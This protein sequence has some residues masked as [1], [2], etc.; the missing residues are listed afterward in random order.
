MTRT[1][2]TLLLA[3]S[4]LTLAARAQDAD[5]P[6][7]EEKPAPRQ[8][9]RTYEAQLKTTDC[10][11]MPNRTTTVD[12]AYAHAQLKVIPLVN[13]TAQSDAN[14]ILIAVRN[15]FDPSIKIYL[16]ADQ[17]AIAVTTYPE[18]IARIESLIHILDRPH[19]SY[20]LT[21]TLTESDAGK[22]L[23]VQH[24][25][26]VAV[27]GQ[28]TTMKQGSKIPVAT[29]SYNEGD[30]NTQTQFTYL[31][32]GMNFDVTA[33]PAGSGISLKAKVEQSSTAPEPVTIAGVNE[34]I[35]RQS[36]IDGTALVTFGKP[37][38][39]GAVDVPAST[40]HIDIDVT[41]EPIP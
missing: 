36:V 13:A 1:I 5:K 3:T 9:F 20:R 8:D 12:C 34:P 27:A 2:L 15:L 40:R 25:S 41:A 38:T 7:Q 6:A 23:G 17:S 19:P 10:R 31:D 35:V 30:K 33:T 4:S 11:K 26:L 29:G 22:R 28:R 18:E 21:F 37:L 24:F 32:I 16:I 14:E 39:L